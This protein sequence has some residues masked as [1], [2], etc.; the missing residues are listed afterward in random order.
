MLAVAACG[1]AE[2]VRIGTEG[3]YPPFGYINESGELEGFEIELGAELCQRANLECT[4]VINDWESIIPNLQ[5]SQYDAIM[6]GMSITE[7]RDRLI[8]FTEAYVPPESSVYVALAGAAEGRHAGQ[9][10]GA[11]RHGPGRSFGGKS[12]G[13]C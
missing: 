9:G 7:E 13:A 12:N 11:D 4:W 6:A 10:R 8:D 1:R 3:A 2:P 5:A